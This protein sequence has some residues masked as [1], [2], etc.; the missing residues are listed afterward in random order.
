[1][2]EMLIAQVT[3]RQERQCGLLCVFL[4]QAI[5]HMACYSPIASE[6]FT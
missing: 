4:P 2:A 5:F 3:E 6:T 1:M